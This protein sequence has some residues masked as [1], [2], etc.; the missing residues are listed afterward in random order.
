ME[1][2]YFK[3]GDKEYEEGWKD[4]NRHIQGTSYIYGH[5]YKG[6]WDDWKGHIT[7]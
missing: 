4:G 3:D 1:N 7:H 6:E 2:I 5:N